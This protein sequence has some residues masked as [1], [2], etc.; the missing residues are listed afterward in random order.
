MAASADGCDGDEERGSLAAAPVCRGGRSR[1]PWLR[2]AVLASLAAVAMAALAG[3]VAQH[4]LQAAPNPEPPLQIEF[5]VGMV[6]GDRVLD[7][8]RR[9]SGD[10]P[11]CPASGCATLTNRLTGSP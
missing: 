1:A 4:A 11:I 10:M 7:D 9:L 8:V 3:T 2:A 6:N 5:V